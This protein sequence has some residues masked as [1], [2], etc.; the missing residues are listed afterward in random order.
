MNEQVHQAFADGN[1]G[2]LPDDAF[3]PWLLAQRWF[4]TKAREI[5]GVCVREAIPLDGQDPLVVAILEVRFPAGTHHL[6]QVPVGLRAARDDDADA[7]V[8]QDGWELYDAL[9]DPTHALRLGHLL[10]GAEA[11][12]A[13]AATLEFH[14]VDGQRLAAAEEVHVMPG[15]MSNTALVYDDDVTLKVF[16]RLQ[17]G[18]NPE[19]EMQWF[20]SEHGF[21]NMPGLLGWYAYRGELFDAT[22]GVASQYVA[23]ASDGWAL[24]VRMIASGDAEALLPLLGSLGEATA[25]MHSV[26]GSDPDNADFA[27]E[28]CTMEA[29]ALIVASIDSQIGEVFRDLPDDPVLA[30]ITTRQQEIHELVAGAGKTDGGAMIR[31]HGDYHLGQTMVADD[32]WFIVDFEGEP[33]RTLVERRMRR[34]PLRDVAGMLRSF[35]YA[36][37]AAERHHDASVPQGWEDRARAAFLDGY[38]ARV[39]DRLLPGHVQNFERMLALFELEKSIYELRYELDHRPE[40]APIPVASMERLL[41]VSEA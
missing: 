13:A 8:A 6:Y 33:A 17:A 16:R 18:T 39:D 35:A 19:L 15:E 27:P 12:E 25:A 31:N 22:L 30:A 5:A 38:R 14:P 21:E 29:M 37:A 4:A 32:H 9:E 2:F 23:D 3:T 10:G 11:V 36:A 28:P 26:L 40:W 41:A 7:I 34:P 1:L 20:L 24:A